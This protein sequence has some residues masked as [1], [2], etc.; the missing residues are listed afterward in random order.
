MAKEVIVVLESAHRQEKCTPDETLSWFY[1]I[2]VI[3]VL[4]ASIT[5][6]I[7]TVKS[8]LHQTTLEPPVRIEYNL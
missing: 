4:T 1:G 3:A 6:I 5:V 8:E 7:F 2:I